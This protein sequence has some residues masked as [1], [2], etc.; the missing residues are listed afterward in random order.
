M[1][2]SANNSIKVSIIQINSGSDK[3]EN[4]KKIS[5]LLDKSLSEKPD[6]ICL[7]EVFN[8]RSSR[9]QSID[10][11]E[12]ILDGKS[13]KLLKDFALSN[14]VW[15]SNGSI[16]E[17]VDEGLPFNTSILINNRGEVVETY[18]KNHLFKAIFKNQEVDEAKKS[19][20]CTKTCVANF[21][22]DNIT[23]GI[24]MSICYDLR[25][26]ELYRG[27]AKQKAQIILVP[28]SFA[29]KTGEAHWETLLRA[30]AIEN[31]AF[32]IAANQWGIVNGL[33]TYGNSMIIDPWG[34]ILARANFDQDEIICADLD[35][36]YLKLVRESLPALDHMKS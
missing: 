34:K 2:S 14:K 22:K 6:L 23:V 16:F 17:K 27:Y 25:F 31:Q 24:G 5:H 11:S 32:V 8:L 4:L 21:K 20:A 1:S 15:I 10:E 36:D 35:I 18:R 29:K 7:P 26:P 9:D 13:T 28:S 12:T 30:R 3:N 19:Q 33:E